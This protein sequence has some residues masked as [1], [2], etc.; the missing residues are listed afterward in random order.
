MELH[1]EVLFDLRIPME[2]QL[3][4]LKTSVLYKDFSI[5]YGVLTNFT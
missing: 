2:E 4:E 3:N 5:K 1:L